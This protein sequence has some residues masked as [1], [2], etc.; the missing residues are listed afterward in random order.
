MLPSKAALAVLRKCRVVLRFIV[1]TLV[2]RSR[3]S[4]LR[5]AAVI[6]ALLGTPATSQADAAFAQPVGWPPIVSAARAHDEL[7]PGVTH[8]RWTLQTAQGPLEISVVTADLRNPFV[9]LVTA[10]HGDVI[11]GPDEPLSAMADRVHAEAGINAD[12]YDI[13]DTGA[14]LGIVVTDGRLEHAP[15]AAAALIVGDGNA[16]SFGPVT[17]RATLTAAG[18]P[19]LPV[20]GVN[21]WTRGA[22]L[23]LVTPRLGTAEAWGAT[24]VVL[25]PSGVAGAYRVR[26]VVADQ[27]ALLALA[28][29]EL[30]IAGHADGA[31]L[32]QKWFAPGDDVSVS[33]DGQPAP[34]TIRWAVGGGPL[35]LRGGAPYDDPTPPAPQETNVRYPVS[36]AGLTADRATLMLVTVDG[37]APARSIGITRPMLAALMR[38]LGA[39]DALAFDSG[40]STEMVV[41]R[42]GALGVSVANVPSDGG[43]RRVADGLFVVNTA[44]LGAPSRLIV[45]AG[46]PAVLVGSSARLRVAAVDEHLQPVD[47]G[48]ASAAFSAR[49]ERIASVDADG[50]VHARATGRADIV[51][52]A[53][54]LEGN[55]T[56]DVVDRVAVLTITGGDEHVAA[57]SRAHFEVDARTA[58]GERIVIDQQSIS[59]RASPG[60]TVKDGEFVAGAQPAR[61]TV[62]ADVGGASARRDVL[63]GEHAQPLTGIPA[64]P[65]WRFAASAPD[66][67]GGVDN[68]P[69]PDGAPA[70]RLAYDFST[71]SGVRAAYA[72]TTLAVPGRPLA[73]ALDV[74]GDGRGEWLRLGYRNADGV[75]DSLTLARHVDWQ[76]WRTLRA[77]LPHGVR[78]PVNIFRIY[79]VETLKTSRE[80]GSLWLRWLSAIQP[81]P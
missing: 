14:P 3:R 64:P 7:G 19:P 45:G 52:K 66:V 10:T 48:G 47:L 54:G 55:V 15:N 35:L 12:Y 2:R 33:V 27:A 59:W 46:A 49:D 25:T 57:G 37:R 72:D 21:D 60:A 36:A 22:T 56:L 81:G 61:V 31:Q 44:P 23:T 8:D 79:A 58:S 29:G 18:K 41:R 40:G 68:M 9:G 38:Q 77:A 42:L 26:T 70:L 43:E 6:A 13:G 30:G 69:A 11:V 1:R 20:S 39:S 32:L 50:T 75:A 24:E 62:S 65:A 74:F 67:G 53:L 4:L 5:G 16:V 80:Q 51:A 73:F 78:F 17:W 76:G 63:V 71:G 28:P 34:G